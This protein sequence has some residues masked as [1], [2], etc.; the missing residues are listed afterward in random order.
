MSNRPELRLEERLRGVNHSHR[1][2]PTQIN[3]HTSPQPSNDSNFGMLTHS[4]TPRRGNGQAADV[5]S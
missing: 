5:F 2:H 3:A 4:A 1:I